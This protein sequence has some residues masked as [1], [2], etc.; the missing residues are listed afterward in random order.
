M[1]VVYGVVN[2]AWAAN[3]RPAS[4]SNRTIGSPE[5]LFWQTPPNPDQKAFPATGPSSKAPVVLSYTL[6][7]MLTHCT[8]WLP[9]TE[10]SVSGGAKPSAP[11][12]SKLSRFVVP[13]IGRCSVCT[14]A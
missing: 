9:P 4:L 5:L 14:A 1:Q 12:P 10:P 6:Y 7:S 11:C 13:T 2:S 8:Y 3:Q